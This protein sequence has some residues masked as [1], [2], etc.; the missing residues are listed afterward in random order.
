M[1]KYF[2]V[3]LCKMHL[4]CGL[5]SP[6]CENKQ[7]P[8]ATNKIATFLEKNSPT[9][10]GRMIIATVIERIEAFKVNIRTYPIG[11]QTFPTGIRLLIMY[12]VHYNFYNGH[13]LQTFPPAAFP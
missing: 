4:C 9:F 6:L 5:K 3:C 10:A 12:N 2:F 8:Y 11:M 7:F 13:R 1:I